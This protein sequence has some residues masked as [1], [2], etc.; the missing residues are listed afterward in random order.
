MSA[1]RAPL[2]ACSTD[3]DDLRQKKNSQKRK[4]AFASRAGFHLPKGFV[5]LLKWAA[6]RE[7]EPEHTRMDSRSQLAVGGGARRN[8]T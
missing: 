7:G 6:A 8:E 1:K 3:D 4:R 5:Y 2:V